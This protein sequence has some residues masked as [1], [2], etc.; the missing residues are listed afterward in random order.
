MKIVSNV[1]I[2]RPVKTVWDF[3]TTSDNMKLWLSG[4]VRVEHL[5]GT[6]GAPGAVSK[7]VYEM[8]GKPFELIEEITVREENAK[9][10][11][12]LIT[13]T[14]LSIIQNEF[15]DRGDGSTE[16]RCESDVTLKGFMKMVTVF[17]KNGFQKRQ[18]D[19]LEKLKTI[20]ESR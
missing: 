5:G 2:N 18:N 8:N 15:I 3:F 19:D 12:V 14:V 17:M 9:L 20:I 4:F 13:P 16:L 6:P 10:S 11:G 7:H 1:L